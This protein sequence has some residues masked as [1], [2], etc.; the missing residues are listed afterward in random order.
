V[1]PVLQVAAS[2]DPK[3]YQPGENIRN[4]QHFGGQGQIIARAA[5]RYRRVRSEKPQVWQEGVWRDSF[6]PQM[7]QMF[8]D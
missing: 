6:C 7:A 8:A 5:S 2:D 1:K 4:Y 3:L